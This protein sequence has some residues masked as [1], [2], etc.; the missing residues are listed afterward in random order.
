MQKHRKYIRSRAE[1]DDVATARTRLHVQDALR[2]QFHE[3]NDHSAKWL[4]PEGECISFLPFTASF[5]ILFTPTDPCAFSIIQFSPRKRQEIILNFA[6]LVFRWFIGR[7]Q[8]M[9]G[10]DYNSGSAKQAVGRH[11]W[12]QQQQECPWLQAFGQ[13]SIP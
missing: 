11:N 9:Q 1:T 5:A 7:S 3:T 8:L 2:A 10:P 12:V 4:H 6:V 13:H